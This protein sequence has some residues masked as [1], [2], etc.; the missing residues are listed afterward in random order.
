LRLH[1]PR[2]KITTPD[3]GLEKEENRIIV[4]WTIT[5]LLAVFFGGV[6]IVLYEFTPPMIEIGGAPAVIYPGFSRETTT[7]FILAVF[8]FVIAAIGTY[9]MRVAPRKE[10]EAWRTYMFF[11]MILF[12]V[13]SLV[14]SVV[15]AHKAGLLRIGR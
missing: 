8:T 6:F 15:F 2:Y 1:K 5:I 10:E 9:L 3:L 14:I 4:F 12:I 11:G 7:E 13:A